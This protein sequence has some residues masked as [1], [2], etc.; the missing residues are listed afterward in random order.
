M[1]NKVSET[2]TSLVKLGNEKTEEF[3]N[4]A[5]KALNDQTELVVSAWEKLF[6]YFKSIR[7]IGFRGYIEIPNLFLYWVNHDKDKFDTK[8]SFSDDSFKIS[9]KA[10]VSHFC[11]GCDFTEEGLEIQK[12]ILRRE[13]LY[14]YA[15][16][17]LVSKWSEAKPKIEEA[18]NTFMTE[19][20]QKAENQMNE[21]LEMNNKL[22]NFVA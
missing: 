15:V 11:W 20:T 1:E 8:F 7:D 21:V 6:E 22:A 5:E 19:K 4:K 9:E 14:R 2:T 10:Y 3:T 12:K 13:R 18:I 17:K 16:N